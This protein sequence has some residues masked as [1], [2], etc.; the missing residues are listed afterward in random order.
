M[1]GL[2]ICAQQLSPIAA[3]YVTNFR[4]IEILGGVHDFPR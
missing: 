3:R 1:E 2:G 4:Y